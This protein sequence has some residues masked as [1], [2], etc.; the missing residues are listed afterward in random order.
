MKSYKGPNKSD[1]ESNRNKK[2]AGDKQQ[3]LIS[4]KISKLK[5]DGIILDFEE[6][7]NFKHTNYEYKNQYQ[8]NFVIKTLDNK[9]II[10]R[11]TNSFKSDRVK[12]GFFD[13]EGIQKHAEFR[14]DIIA[15]VYLVSD[16]QSPNDKKQFIAKQ[17]LYKEK[18]YYSPGHLFFFHE[19]ED[20]LEEYKN[21][22]CAKLEEVEEDSETY[23]LAEKN[24]SEKGSY[25]GKRGNDYEKEIVDIINNPENLKN[26]ISKSI[27]IKHP[28][29]IIITKI[30]SDLNIK[31]STIISISATNTVPLLKSG[32]NPKTDI[33]IGITTPTNSYYKTI[34]V[35]FPNSKSSVITCHDYAAKDYIRVLNCEHDRLKDYLIEFQKNPSYK[36]FEKS[37]EKNNKLNLTDF[38]TKLE[39]IRLKFMEWVLTGKHDEE[40]LIE[41]EKQIS[42]YLLIRKGSSLHFFGMKEYMNLLLKEKGPALH[43][44]VPFGWTYPSKQR[45]KRIQLKLPILV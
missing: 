36:D 40:N 8:A 43:Y 25:Y 35:K 22:V 38:I 24:I 34:S 37:I 7:V 44:S 30:L 3:K 15:S 10:V 29:N 1:S 21:S 9:Y 5:K 2:Q 33:I 19:F 31:E 11:S 4:D 45:G 18:V 32:G 26:Y 16:N 13:L 12:T 41:P 23:N 39:S 20:F 42:E 14:K 17:K 6:D 27:D 28:F